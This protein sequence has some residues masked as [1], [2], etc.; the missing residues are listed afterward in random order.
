MRNS[1]IIIA[2]LI[3]VIA[4]GVTGVVAYHLGKGEADGLTKDLKTEIKEL[5][6]EQRDA[7]I[8][9][10]VSEQMSDI[11]QEEKLNSD[12]QRDIAE[13]QRHEAEKQSQEAEA[14]RKVAEQKTVEAEQQTILAKENERKAKSAE[15]LA[16]ENENK[17]KA[18]ETLANRKAIEAQRQM[19][20]RMGSSLGTAAINQCG[21]DMNLS[22]QLAYWSWY[23]L[24]QTGGN[25]YF[26]DTYNALVRILLGF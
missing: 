13:D 17:A 24:D 6:Q 18:A 20:K 2:A 21:N 25:K 14:Q 22:R 10:R 23:Y 16:R 9:R 11:A 1:K 4:A 19:Q 7:E 15:A 12:R 3:A 5:T 26:S 8:T